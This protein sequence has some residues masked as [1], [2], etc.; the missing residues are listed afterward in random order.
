[1]VLLDDSDDGIVNAN[2]CMMLSSFSS[3][4]FFILL[5]S[6]IYLFEFHC[7]RLHALRTEFAVSVC[8]CE[9]D[10]GGF[11]D[12]MNGDYICVMH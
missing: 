2:L 11:W 1:M 4:F 3:F 12:G 6:F 5:H 7:H 9:C 8:E 10:L